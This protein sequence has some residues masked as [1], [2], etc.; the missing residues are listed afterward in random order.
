MAAHNPTAINCR[1]PLGSRVSDASDQE[2]EAVA[3]AANFSLISM[4]LGFY[5]PC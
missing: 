4:I 3:K 5:S 1:L 2:G